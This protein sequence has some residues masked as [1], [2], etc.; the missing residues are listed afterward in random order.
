MSASRRQREIAAASVPVDLLQQRDD[1]AIRL[2]HGGLLERRGKNTRVRSCRDQKP[3]GT[4]YSVFVLLGPIWVSDGVFDRFGRAMSDVHVPVPVAGLPSEPSAAAPVPGLH[5]SDSPPPF[6]AV[7]GSGVGAHSTNFSVVQPSP[8][9]SQDYDEGWV[10]VS[11]STSFPLG[12]LL[13][14]FDLSLSRFV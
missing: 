14:L 6:A 9:S 4:H 12:F 2:L 8:F 7:S 5:R 11:L 10:K 13:L 3:Q 1:N